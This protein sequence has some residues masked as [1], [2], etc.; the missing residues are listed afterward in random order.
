MV[1]LGRMPKVVSSKTHISCKFLTFVLVTLILAFFLFVL[2]VNDIS[3]PAF[4]SSVNFLNHSRNSDKL[5]IILIGY[6]PY[7]WQYVFERFTL[8]MDVDMDV[9]LVSSGTFSRALYRSCENSSWSYLSTKKNDL[10]VAQNLAITY[11]P[12]ASLIF[13]L[14]EDIFIT[15]HYFTKMLRAYEHARAGNMTPGVISP[16]LTVNLFTS[17]LLLERFDKL[18]LFEQLFGHP[19]LPLD[20]ARSDSNVSLFFWGN[21]GHLKSIDEMNEIVGQDPLKETPCPMR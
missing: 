18:A 6:K 1:L 15:K 4:S 20:R 9:C 13:K 8:Y 21:N 16:M 11:H 5:C 19:K 14:D 12:N 17:Y 3:F 10:S 7:L 2:Y